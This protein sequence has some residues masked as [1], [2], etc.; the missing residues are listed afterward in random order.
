MKVLGLDLG[1]RTLGIALSDELG[2]L[3][4]PVET[5]RF[6]EQAFDLAKDKV[7]SL[8]QTEH[9]G[10]IVLGHPKN[11]DGSVGEQGRICEAFKA[12]LETETSVPIHLWDERLTSKMASSMM[13]DQNLN[14]TKRKASIDAMAAVVI[15]QGYLDRQS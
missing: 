12:M 7:L 14:R 6:D 4:R 3:A 15:L 5:F 1:N 11:M 13:K 2:F 10:A 8:I 9:I